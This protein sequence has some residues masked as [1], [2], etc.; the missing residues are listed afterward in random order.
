MSVRDATHDTEP[1]SMA[2]PRSS[3]PDAPPS[4]GLPDRFGKNVGFNY[5]ATVAAAL[6]GLILTPVLADYLGTKSFGIWALAVSVV[7]YLELLELGFGVATSKLMAQDAYVRPKRVVKTLNT[8]FFLL[9]IL[10]AFALVVGL[11]LSLLAPTLFSVP[12][13]LETETIWVFALLATA[14]A[15]SLPFDS[16]GGALAAHQ[17]FDLWAI[18]NIMLA[19]LTAAGYVAVVLAGG[20]LLWLAI[21][22]ITASVAM[23]F[24]RWRFLRGILP[25]FHL[26]R[27]LI[28]RTRARVI[29]SLSSWFLV[30][31][32][33]ETI[34]QR[35]DLPV[36]GVLLG[37]QA[38]AIYFVGSKLAK[39]ASGGLWPLA[40]VF[41]PHA[42]ALSAEGEQEQLSALV[43][44]GT[45]A[46][47]LFGVPVTIG[48]IILGQPA[49]H[50]WVGDGFTGAAAVTAILG[51][52]LGLDA[53][54]QASWQTLAGHGRA[55][56]SAY[57]AAAEAIVNLSYSIVLGH[58]MGI[59]GVALGTL[60][61]VA[62]VKL[63]CA[64]VLGCR[65]VD[66]PVRTL[67]RD[68][69]APHL[70]PAVSMTALLLAAHF[71]L[72]VHDTGTA[73]DRLAAG[74]QV[75]V[76]GLVAVVVYLTVYFSV[77]ATASE[78]HRARAT[79]IR[80]TGRKQAIA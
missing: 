18:S 11:G 50:A 67:L 8:T 53:L 15:I 6:T 64:I 30:R 51:L 46:I 4:D 77:S 55:R 39:L 65:S 78:R 22:T 27:K 38:A 52:A 70:L 68:A 45:R 54:S 59:T 63:P 56:H 62:T 73:A 16:F 13:D 5:A 10:G 29:A 36:V 9:S 2:A 19:A 24:V 21:V 71:A 80:L 23:H 35:I 37:L 76:E 41:F 61:G 32:L 43:S 20:G 49:I 28:D 60:I 40:S 72:P 25:E 58:Y 74:V 33:S 66:L 3:E 1:D 57:I 79:W 31:E 69:V 42:S 47:L 48:L 26:D 75:A 17:R 7:T 44:D 14:I 34:S 12:A